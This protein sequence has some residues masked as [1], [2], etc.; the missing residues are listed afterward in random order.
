MDYDYNNPTYGSNPILINGKVDSM[1][2]VGNIKKILD[3][4]RNR[5]QSPI[6]PK[7]PKLNTSKEIKKISKLLDKITALDVDVLGSEVLNNIK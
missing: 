3:A 7:K 5:N 2:Y 1:S 6:K 4:Y